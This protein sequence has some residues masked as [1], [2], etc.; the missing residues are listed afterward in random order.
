MPEKKY[1]NE[2]KIK[3]QQELE[4]LFT[5]DWGGPRSELAL[6]Y[7]RE[8]VIP[9]LISCLVINHHYLENKTFMEILSNKLN[10]E[11][12]Y[13]PAFADGL[14]KDIVKIA[15]K[16]LGRH[17]KP[18]NHPWHPWEVILRMLT[19]GKSISKIIE[20]TGFPESYIK[21]LRKKYV[22]YLNLIDRED[23]N[24]RFYDIPELSCSRQ[25][26]MFM[27]DFRNRFR[28]HKNYYVRLQAEEV[29]FELELPVNADKLLTI[30]EC[31]YYYEGLMTAEELLQVLKGYSINNS[32]YNGITII[33]LLQNNY[34][35]TSGKVPGKIS[36]SPKGAKLAAGVLAP[37]LAEEIMQKLKTADNA[38]HHFCEKLLDRNPK[39][40][41]EVIR[42]LA[43]YKDSIVLNLFDVMF[44]RAS[45]QVLLAIISACGEL[46]GDKPAAL[47]ARAL[48]HRDSMVRVKACQAIADNKH[49]SLYFPLVNALND[50]V[51]LVR[52]NAAGALGRLGI[53][54]AVKY[55][56]P[57]LNNPEEHPSVRQA[58]REA[59]AELK[60]VRNN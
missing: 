21:I 60:F 16:I 26:V 28:L 5:E 57:I 32:R 34:L 8:K 37:R 40:V 9:K 24:K 17:E 18:D 45:K 44:G 23:V 58:A 25:L 15:L 1:P 53:P 47:L 14:S 2:L 52:E 54:A 29:I 51:Q 10:T 56:K 13:P 35:T 42:E 20:K 4:K 49:K 19:I 11:F 48:R 43:N 22:M 30:L 6:V 38:A 39:V 12:A 59:I 33:I 31:I 27:Q 36:L 55:L 3:L 50:S 41:E 7:L 46:E